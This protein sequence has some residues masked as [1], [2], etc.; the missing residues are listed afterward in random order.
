MDE[1]VAKN[2]IFFSIN[3]LKALACLGIILMHLKSNLDYQLAGNFPIIMI[4]NFTNFVFLF[5]IISSF[6]LCCGYYEKIKNNQINPE[7]FYSKRIKKI[8][9]FFAFL[10][11]LDIIIEHNISSIIEGMADLTLL[12]GL[13]QKDISVVG[14]GW[15]L[16]LIFIFYLMFPFFTYLFSNKRRALI[17]TIISIFMNFSCIY[18]FNV[19]RTNMFYSFVYFCIGGLIYLYKNNICNFFQNKRILG[20]LIILIL[21]VLYFI[22]PVDNEYLSSLKII[23]LFT[24]LLCYAISF[25]SIILNNKVTNLI[26]SISFELYLCHMM[27]F[28]IIEA[29]KLTNVFGN[30]WISY[31]FVF[32]LV[33]TGSILII[34]FFKKIYI[35]FERKVLG[36]ENI[37]SK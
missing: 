7:K 24:S 1:K 21:T 14:V 29:L 10:V 35:L 30:N 33:V 37:I 12:F 36:N 20:L 17:I 18:Y 19:G 23:L 9:P 3:G 22:L 16:G 28:R 11:V 26:S 32:I 27:V 5:M 8:L 15:F 6:G 31:L 13:L 34:M 25:D 2:N 4:S